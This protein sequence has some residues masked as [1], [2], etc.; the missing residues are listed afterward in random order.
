MIDI[1]DFLELYTTCDDIE[2]YDFLTES[3]VFSGDPTDAK[4]EFGEYTVESFDI[5]AN[6]KLIINTSIDD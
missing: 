1:Y 3:I 5:E 6:G 4:H 2:I